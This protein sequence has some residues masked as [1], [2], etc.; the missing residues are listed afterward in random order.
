VDH[1]TSLRTGLGRLTD[2]FDQTLINLEHELC[3]LGDDLAHTVDSYLGLS[4]TI[5]GTSGPVSLTAWREPGA[6]APA[7]SL[8]IPLPLLFRSTPGSSLTLYA[9]V[10][11]ALVDLAADLSFALDQPLTALALDRHLPHPNPHSHISGLT[12][13]SHINQALG[14]LLA[15]GRTRQQAHTELSERAGRGQPRNLHTTAQTII[16]SAALGVGPN[17][18]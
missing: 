15:C 12:E 7:T 5:T 16:N 10:P 18:F 4:I 17:P 8:Q 6:P 3:R 13:F 11:G 2:T 9:A 1:S 14:V